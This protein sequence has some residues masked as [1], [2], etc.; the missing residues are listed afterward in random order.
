MASP[1]VCGLSALLIQDYRARFPG[2]DMRNST[3]KILLAQTAV[4]LGNAGPDYQF[5]YGSVRIV[6]AIDFMRSANFRESSVGQ[7]GVVSYTV[8]VTA[9][10][11][12]LKVMLAWDDPAGTPNVVPSLINDLDLRVFSPTSSQAFPWTLNP[13]NPSAAAVRTV[14]NSRDNIEQVLVDNPAAGTW[15]VE[16][17]GFNVPQGPQPFSVSA[18]PNLGD[19]GPCNP[20]AAPTGV[21]ASDATSCSSVT[22]SWNAATGATGYSIWRNTVDN[23]GSATEIG[24]D[25]ASPFDDATA[26]QGQTYFYWVKAN[27]ACGESGFRA[28]RR[29]RHR[30]NVLH[31]R[32]RLLE[33]RLRRDR[34]R[35]LAEYGERRRDRDFAGPRLGQP[36]HGQHGRSRH[37]VFLLGDRRQRLRRQPVQHL[38][39]RLCPGQHHRGPNRRGR[40]RWH[41]LHFGERVLERRQRCDH[42]HDL[43][44]YRQ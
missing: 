20:P 27:N 39:Q 14:R 26:S 22:V 25:S 17:F 35:S 24:T 9:G 6:P 36:V 1:T 19:G 34:V 43:A 4:D 30:R 8:N 11:S 21:T 32:H 41:A 5:G 15:T 18:S 10:T 37:D 7:G 29:H 13:S 38:R 31:V 42:L 33:R 44:Q 3:L 2:P 16:V 40:D 23:S 12:Q 28:D